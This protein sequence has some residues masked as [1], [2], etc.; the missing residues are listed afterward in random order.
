MGNAIERSLVRA[1]SFDGL[2]LTVA[3]EPASNDGLPW[4]RKVWKIVDHN[5]LDTDTP[6][7]EE[8][9]PKS[10]VYF[11]AVFGEHYKPDCRLDTRSALRV[12]EIHILWI[13]GVAHGHQPLKTGISLPE[14]RHK[15]NSDHMLVPQRHG[16]TIV[17]RSLTHA[18]Q[19]HFIK[20]TFYFYFFYYFYKVASYL[21]NHSL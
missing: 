13:F 10:C 17:S 21:K 18:Y 3:L 9:D 4:Q 1:P 5:S 16:I 15:I 14:R 2:I 19:H 11:A 20:H 7:A 8:G 6:Q 12:R